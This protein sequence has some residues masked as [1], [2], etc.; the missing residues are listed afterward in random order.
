[1]NGPPLPQQPGFH[2]DDDPFA[3]DVTIPNHPLLAIV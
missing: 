1:M 2:P 3:P